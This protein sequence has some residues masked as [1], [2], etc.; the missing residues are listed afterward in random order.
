MADNIFDKWDSE[1]DIDGLIKDTTEASKGSSDFK[2]VPFGTY[3]VKVDKMELKS[4]KKGSP[5]LSIWFKVL[6]G[7][8]KNSLIFY[9]QVLTTGFG[10]HSSKEMLKA[11]SDGGVDVEFLNF[12]QYS[13]LILDVHE[14]IDGKYEFGLEYGQN[15][16]GFNTYKITEV[17]DV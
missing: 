17:F 15:N 5:M 13:G 2:E 3:E 9:N 6:E 10:I 14:Y 16:K 7:D 12:K 1:I 4:S 8:F 11:L